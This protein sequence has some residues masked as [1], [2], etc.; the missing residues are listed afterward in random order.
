MKAIL[1]TLMNF[2]RIGTLALVLFLSLTTVAR[3]DQYDTL[4][5][6]RLNSLLSNAGSATSVA[7]KANGYWIGNGTQ[8]AMNAS[9]SGANFYLWSDLPL[10]SVSSNI[11]TTY[12]RLQSMALAYAMPTCSLYGNASLAAAVANGLDWMNAN[13]FTATATNPYDNW[14]DWEV[15][16]PQALNDTAV[17][18]YAALTGTQIANYGAAMD[19]FGP[20]GVFAATGFN[21]NGLTAAN[22]SDVVLVTLI[23]G[24][25]TKSSTK[26]T[27]GQTK[28]S[29]VFPYVTNGD[30][31]YA[32]GSYVFHGNI[33]YTGHYGYVQL[34]N[35]AAI[36]NLLNGSTWAITDPNLP[37]VYNWITNGFEPLIYN[38]ALMDMSRGRVNSWSNASEYDDGAKV[39]AA[40][41]QVA[42]FAPA[43][44]AASLNAFVASPRLASGQFHFANMDR[45]T[46]FRSGFGFGLS[47]SSS[48]IA[49]FE[50][51][52]S[53][54]DLKGW[55]TGDGMTYLYVGATDT[56]F[57][58]DYWPT[59]DAYHLPG[60]TVEQG[61]VPQPSSTD[62]S[63]VGGAQVAGTYGAAGMAL[64]PAASSSASS[65]LNGK[66][67]WFMLDNEIVCLG[68][69]VT[70]TTNGHEVDTTVENRRLGTSPTNN[71]YA[72]GVQYP[73]T[74]GWSSALTSATW[75][76]LDGVGGYY[77]PGG[78][79]NLQA[80]FVASSGS[81]TQIHPSDSDAT[82]YTDNYLKLYFKHGVKPTNASY[83]YVLLPG[84][85]S[86]NVSAYA[87][88]PDISVVAN[89]STVQAVKKVRLGVV[90][91][92]FWGVVGGTADLI[93]VNKQASV[94]VSE[95]YNGI[96][97]GVSD[98]TQNNTGTITVTLNR[99]G[100]SLVSADSGITVT[101]LTPKIIFTVNV[102]AAKGKTFQASFVQPAQ[103]PAITSI[104]TASGNQGAAFTYQITSSNS[105]TSYGAS[106]LPAGLGMDTGTG[107]ISGVPTQTGTFPATISATNAGGTGTA[108]LTIT[109]LPPAPS[110][111][112]GLSLAGIQGSALRYQI[113]ATNS[114]TSYG[115]SGLP[116]GLNVDT[117]TGL[118]SGTPNATGTTSATITATNV[119]GTGSATLTV[120]VALVISDL[121]SN[122]TTT[123]T[124][125]C[126]AN[127]TAIQVECW[128]GGGAGGSALRI[129]DSGS[130]EYGGG[131]AGGGY[132]KLNSTTVTPGTTY[133]ISVGA[134]GVNNSA[135]NDTTVAGGDSWI[136]ATNTPSTTIIAKGGAGGESAIG[137]TS[138]TRYG[139]GGTGT[140]T[141]SVGDI[142][143]AGGNGATSASSIAGGG[144]SSAGTGASG[145]AATSNA[146]ATAP[147][148]GGDGGTGQTISSGGGGNGSAPGGGGSGARASGTQQAGGTGG[149]GKIVL[150]VKTLSSTVI[151]GSLAQTFDGTP[152]AA[153]ATTTPAGLAVNFTY[154]GSPAAPTAAGSYTV[155]G[156]INSANYSGSATGTLSIAA[157][158]TAWRQ[159]YFSTTANTGTAADAAD[160]D[161]DGLSNAQEYIFGT[162]PTATNTGALLGAS[163]SGTNIVLTFVAR[164]SAG[165]GYAGLARHYAV[166]T[167]TNLST[168]LSWVPVTGYSD[169]LGGNQTVIITR[170]NSSSNTFYRLKAW[171]Q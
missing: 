31:F 42:L 64:Y 55:F 95:T 13:V 107:V 112:S 9:P 157:A 78:A 150:T 94:M 72:N 102:N 28:L 83:A 108:T 161:G 164:Q 56:Q 34:E 129:P 100:S 128:G 40:I 17:L 127:V 165:T 92:N 115:A 149:A 145:T 10:G 116:A 154:N 65:T 80:S 29:K 134:G 7:T 125:T 122:F 60:T 69:G 155:V 37:N 70:C 88:N 139:V 147:S 16:A 12:K 96:T 140:A 52:F 167:T 106:G 84:M 45:V 98:P 6:T 51:L 156:T 21:W 30:G 110:I 153:T 76:A 158:V 14:Y 44:T 27:L 26:L 97:I 103:A 121:V 104:T 111:T 114:P 124:W 74:I 48:R 151:L 141:G 169:I 85:T 59:V 79:T 35:V 113:A 20:D 144:G 137:N 148:G 38:G 86:S 24:I 54:S 67:S 162:L 132:A 19:N 99:A 163:S 61:Y 41:Q 159:L 71:F 8:V 168:A 33:A 142:V 136:N 11:S 89:T 87:Q 18:L 39:L 82:V 53:T 146:G 118:I 160:P 32:D 166:E 133:F 81:W 131:G 90:G 1:P 73:P 66:K 49:N 4:R 135:V 43:A 63:W 3:A 75:C 170:P 25:L 130:I 47:M 123:G 101:Q 138:T 68:A 109:V 126:P 93:T 77:F 58:D 36:V 152:K 117:S 5:T 91:A 15:T 22:T 57:T 120:T 105:P 62:Q 2:F 143:Y 119:G 171:L 50:N 23:R 46:S